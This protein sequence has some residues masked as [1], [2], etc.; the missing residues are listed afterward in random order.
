MKRFD[1]LAHF[2]GQFREKLPN[3]IVRREAVRIFGFEIFLA[4]SAALVD[5]EKSGVRHPFGHP[6][7]FCVKDVKA[8]NDLGIRV[9]QQRKLDVVPLSEVLEDSWTIVANCSQVVP[10]LLESPFG[11]L[12]LHE[13]RFAERSPVGGTEEKEN[14]PF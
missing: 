6:L 12:Q 7:R 3:D 13:L 2:L 8:A 1:G 9:G 14:R 10:L 5:I 4:N 11:I